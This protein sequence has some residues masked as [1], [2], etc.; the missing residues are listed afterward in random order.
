MVD[1]AAR[2]VQDRPDLDA[3]D[4]V[5]EVFASLIAD[6]PETPPDWGVLLARLSAVVPVGGDTPPVEEVPPEEDTAVVVVRRVAAEELRGRIQRVMGYMTERQRVITRL[7]LFEGLSV[8]EIA[9]LIGTSSSNVSQIIIRCLA[10]LGPSLLRC[11]GFDEQDLERL[12]PSRRVLTA[13]PSSPLPDEDRAHRPETMLIP[14]ARRSS[15]SPD[16]S[17]TPAPGTQPISFSSTKATHTRAP[18]TGSQ[19]QPSCR[20]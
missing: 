3:A 13:R 7:R 2:R 16:P 8:G 4:I 20:P 5:Q 12:R 1:A 10:K 17:R 11:D 15:P 19:R 9:T 6:P 14:E 18:V